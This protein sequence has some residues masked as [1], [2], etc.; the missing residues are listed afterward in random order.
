MGTTQTFEDKQ[1]NEET[2][3]ALNFDCLSPNTKIK[4]KP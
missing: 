1:E 2:I 4:E 3:F